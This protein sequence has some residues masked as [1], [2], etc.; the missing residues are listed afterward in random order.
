MNSLNQSPGESYVAETEGHTI[1]SWARYYDMVVGILSLGR[2]RKFRQ[3]ALDLIA[4]EPGM[5]ILDVGCGT[6]SLAIAAKQNQ[7]VNGTIV[8]IDPSSNMIDLA[9]QK[10][11]KAGVEINFQVGVIENIE[12]EASHF[13]L[14]LSSLMMHHLTDELKETGLQE[15]Y[16]VLKPKGTLLII[17]LDP[18]AFSLAS[19]VHG[20]SSQLSVELENTRRIM[21]SLE[22]GPVESGSVNFRGFF[23]LKG[24]KK[25]SDSTLETENGK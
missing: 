3:T 24:N 18:G 19:L 10:A 14:V 13:D 8:G 5:K 9:R 20:H 25:I 17:E 22:F 1:H 2:E 15:V 23:Y 4:I 12:F 16:R 21:E 6:G 11:L 7:G